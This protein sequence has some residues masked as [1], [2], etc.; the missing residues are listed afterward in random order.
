MGG[1]R[2]GCA[3]EKLP[4]PRAPPMTRA[5][6]QALSTSLRDPQALLLSSPA[7]FPTSNS[8]SIQTSL[9]SPGV[10][11]RVNWGNSSPPRLAGTARAAATSRPASERSGPSSEPRASPGS[12]QAARGSPAA[13]G[14]RPATCPCF[15]PLAQSA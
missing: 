10:A 1:N 4:V 2:D 14:V 8:E 3:A 12:G 5:S 6:P 9:P 7:P 13:G 11:K 15:P